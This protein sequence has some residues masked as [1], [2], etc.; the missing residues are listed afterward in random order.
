[1]S[2]IVLEDPK[3][4]KKAKKDKGKKVGT[5]GMVVEGEEPR[6]AVAGPSRISD[7][8]DSVSWEDAFRSLRRRIRTLEEQA[9]VS[10]RLDLIDEA[11]NDMDSTREAEMDLL[12]A[13]MEVAEGQLAGHDTQLATH[14]KNFRLLKS[15]H[16]RS[17]G[18][19]QDLQAGLQA[20]QSQVEAQRDLIDSLQHL[21]NAH[22]DLLQDW[23]WSGYSRD[24]DDDDEIPDAEHGEDGDLIGANT[25]GDLDPDHVHEQSDTEHLGDR[26]MFGDN[27]APSSPD[28]LANVP[29]AQNTIP[30]DV[31]GDGPPDPESN[32]VD[33]T[34]EVPQG[35]SITAGA[36]NDNEDPPEVTGSTEASPPLVQLIPPT[37]VSPDQPLPAALSI[38]GPEPDAGLPVLDTAPPVHLVV[39][40]SP[41]GRSR[42]PQASDTEQLAGEKRKAGEDAGPASKKAKGSET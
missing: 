25:E 41:R 38:P 34:E 22:E 5:A 9:S 28:S 32:T 31:S 2:T 23:Q 36:A 40:R 20:L 16:D 21:V 29:E 35:L 12:V 15:S 33:A 13:R 8:S 27:S 26:L 42:T 1:M 17:S 6:T 39:R 7:P 18:Y 4:P 30:L 37:P 10:D 19:I 11:L 24:T 3:V 14:H